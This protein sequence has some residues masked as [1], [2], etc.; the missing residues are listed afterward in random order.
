[1][2]YPCPQKHIGHPLYY[3]HT[4]C[5]ITPAPRLVALEKRSPD[6]DQKRLSK[7]RQ[8]ISAPPKSHNPPVVTHPGCLPHCGLLPAETLEKRSTRSGPNTPPKKSPGPIRA[9]KASQGILSGGHR[10]P[11]GPSPC[12]PFYKNGPG[13]P[14]QNC[15]PKRSQ[16]LLCAAGP[17]KI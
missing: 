17:L 14:Q 5:Q 7:N 15:P 12:Q 3:M 2:V 4:A 6:L 16:R 8:G 1:M 11:I 10:Q 9:P 13:V